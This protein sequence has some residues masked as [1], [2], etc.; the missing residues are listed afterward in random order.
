MLFRSSSLCGCGTE[1]E[2]SEK[3]ALLTAFTTQDLK[4]NTYSQEV[5]EDY[6]LTMINIWATFC[7]PCISEMPELGEISKEYEE[8]GVQI[9]GVVTD[10]SGEDGIETANTL[11]E[12]TG[13]NYLHILPSESLK[14]ILTLTSVVPTTVFVDHEGNQVG[15]IY[16]GAKSKESWTKIIEEL[17][18]EVQ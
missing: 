6:N 13:A 12:Q 15:K 2:Q 9:I 17:L 1:K 18:V 10:V 3:T 16:T 4:G 5:L 8:R 14:P 11:I 7:S